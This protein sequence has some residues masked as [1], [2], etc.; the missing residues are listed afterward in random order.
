VAIHRTARI[1][2]VVGG[3]ELIPHNQIPESTC[4]RPVRDHQRLVVLELETAVRVAGVARRP[5]EVRVRYLIRLGELVG[6]L[7]SFM[8]EPMG[9]VA[10]YTNR[11]R[12][13][14]EHGA[15]PCGAGP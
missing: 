4:R 13:D 3:H 9:V 1:G 2:D 7:R 14:G 10:A 15:Q 12:H 6:H 5:T 11:E 8:P